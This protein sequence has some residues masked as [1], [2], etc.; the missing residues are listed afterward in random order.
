MRPIWRPRG[1]SAPGPTA[2]ARVGA[3]LLS[4]RLPPG[5][6]SSGRTLGPR[7]LHIDIVDYPGEWLID[8]ALL[9]HTY[10]DWSADARRRPRS[11][12]R[13]PLRRVSLLRHHA[14]A[15]PDAEPVAIA[16]AATSPAY[17][18]PASLRD[19]DLAHFTP[20]RFLMPG[21]LAGSP[22]SP[23]SASSQTATP[24]HASAGGKA[25]R[26]L[27]ARGR[28]AVLPRSLPETRP[29]GGA[30]RRARRDQRR[31]RRARGSA[32]GDGRDPVG[33]PPGRNAFLTRLFLGRRVEKI[34]FAA[35]K[36][37][38]LHHRQH[39]QASPRSWRR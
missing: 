7:R 2:H 36:A 1:R 35:T 38:H 16:G 37:D 22:R 15:Q 31:P 27:Q 9:D 5:L 19:G 32:P 4:V 24:L 11:S 30:R 29:A 3:P 26:R 33:L 39:A 8:L 6:T 12:P 23:F 25:L 14:D 17:L 28:E 10:A 34:L 21:E 20:G 13:E 18:A